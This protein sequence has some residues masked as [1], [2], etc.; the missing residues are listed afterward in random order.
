MLLVLFVWGLN[1]FYRMKER[2]STK[3]GVHKFSKNV[4]GTSKFKAPEE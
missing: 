4:G 1:G 3:A 2:T